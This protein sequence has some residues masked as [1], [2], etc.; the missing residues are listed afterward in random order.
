MSKKRDL[1]RLGHYMLK[2]AVAEM[3]D[4]VSNDE[5]KENV[6]DTLHLIATIMQKAEADNKFRFSKFD[7]D[8]LTVKNICDSMNIDLSEYGW[9]CDED[10]KENIN[11][12]IKR[13][14]KKAAISIAKKLGLDQDVKVTDSDKKQ[15]DELFDILE[16][17]TG[18]K[19]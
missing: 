1:D 6:I 16:K 3:K 4:D 12:K 14:A 11:D 8:N 7:A 19:R 2:F 17:I 13:E 18:G 15:L 5:P 10:D 9:N